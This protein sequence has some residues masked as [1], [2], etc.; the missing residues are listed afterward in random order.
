MKAKTTFIAKGQSFKDRNPTATP[1]QLLSFYGVDKYDPKSAWLLLG[2]CYAN[3][4]NNLSLKKAHH[5]KS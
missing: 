4:L 1:T 2:F 5:G 3:P